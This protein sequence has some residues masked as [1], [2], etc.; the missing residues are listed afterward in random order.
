MKLL[1][2][3]LCVALLS[4]NN[5]SYALVDPDALDPSMSV[6]SYLI[7]AQAVKIASYKQGTPSHLKVILCNIC[8]EKTYP[9]STT[10]TLILFL[11]T[12]DKSELTANL[13]KKNFAEVRLAVDREKGEIIYLHLG[14]SVDDELS[15][16]QDNSTEAKR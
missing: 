6:V 7:P 10:A 3:T 2:T 13:L 14:A 15:P 12:L 16:Q 11:K 8:A 4:F 9:I 1:L 5:P